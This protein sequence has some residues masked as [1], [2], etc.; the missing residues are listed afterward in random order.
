MD[1]PT[2]LVDI[3]APK[4]QGKGGRG[5]RR[6]QFVPPPGH[7]GPLHTEALSTQQFDIQTPTSHD[8][9]TSNAGQVR[10]HAHADTN[11]T[12]SRGN[13]K[14]KSASMPERKRRAMSRGHIK[15]TDIAN[16]FAT[17]VPS[18]IRM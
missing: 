11:A 10:N 3:M 5:A 7:S 4:G 15:R 12:G 9:P 18:T 2:Q 13:N 8:N 14:D 17:E 6:T 16:R 1:E